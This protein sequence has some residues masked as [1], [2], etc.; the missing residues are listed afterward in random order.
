MELIFLCLL[1]GLIPAMIAS[2]KGHSFFPWYIYGV[3]LFIIALVH[4]LLL[5]NVKDEY[6]RKTLQALIEAGQKTCPFCAEKI[7]REA[8]VCRYCQR[9]QSPPQPAS[10]APA[11]SPIVS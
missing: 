8:T 3:L 11:N 10:V 7:K 1:L 2:S 4:S 5:K 9:E 6:E